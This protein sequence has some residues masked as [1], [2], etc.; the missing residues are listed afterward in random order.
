MENP[1]RLTLCAFIDAFGWEILK[2][3]PFLD[4]VLTYRQ[5]LVSMLG[6]SSTCIP[7]I[8]T[9]RRPEKHGHMAFF[10]Y[11]PSTSPFR[12]WRFLRW[13]PRSITSR[14]R[15]RHLISKIIQKVH[16]YTGYFQIYNIPFDHFHLFD[17]SEKKDIY[18]PGGISG[19]CPTLFDR[20][21]EAGI[22]FHKS[23][24]RKGE[25]ENYDSLIEAVQKSDI[26]VGY[27]YWAQM[28]GLLHEQTKEGDRIGEKIRWYESRLKQLLEAARSHYEEVDL[29]VVS[30]HGMCTAGRSVD[31]MK[32]I[33]STGLQFGLDYVAVYDST[34]ARFWFLKEGA[35]GR[36]EAGL[37]AEP[38]GRILSESELRT[39]GCWF[40]DSR[41]GE[42]I[43]L[44]DPGTLINPSHMGESA[45]A[46]MHGYEPSHPDSL[47]I[48]LSTEAPEKPLHD[49]ADI[50]PYLLKRC[51][52][53]MN[54]RSRP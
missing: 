3:H 53:G 9:G 46:G 44:M 50:Q 20:L 8:L 4:D 30:D 43:Y 7:T 14:G 35:R 36:I 1:K 6:Y 23:D 42:L 39:Y 17:Y 12:Y 37:R 15:V 33:S 54:E 2:K 29:I 51:G 41:F 52:V 31:L 27:L 24:W 48:F 21:R 16:G 11:S 34:M 25:Q 22:P 13:F 40:E 26:R 47:A 28:D 32:R 49:L 10:Y 19:G 18:E 5:P 38:S 45:P